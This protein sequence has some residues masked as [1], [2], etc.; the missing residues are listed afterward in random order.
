MLAAEMA[1]TIAKPARSLALM[2]KVG[3]FSDCGQ[4]RP[5]IPTLKPPIPNRTETGRQAP[6]SAG[7]KLGQNG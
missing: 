1:R 7:A 6:D 3:S 2:C 5:D 4:T